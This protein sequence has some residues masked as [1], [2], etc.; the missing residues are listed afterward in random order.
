MLLSLEDRHAAV[1]LHDRRFYR[2]VEGI[3]ATSICRWG[4]HPYR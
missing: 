2:Y 1:R 4:T 3:A